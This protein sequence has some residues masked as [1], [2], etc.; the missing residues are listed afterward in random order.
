MAVPARPTISVSNIRASLV[1]LASSAYAELPDAFPLD[2]F[3]ADLGAVYSL[4]RMLTSY[5]GPLINV[6]RLSDGSA[7]DFGYDSNGDLDTAAILTFVG[8]SSAV[9]MQ[10]YD[11]GPNGLDVAPGAVANGPR[12]VLTGTLETINGRPAMG[13]FPTAGGNQ[14]WFQRATVPALTAFGA[15]EV[16][17]FAVFRQEGAQARNCLLQHVVSG[18]NLTSILATYDDV[19]YWDHADDVA[20]A[21]RINVAQPTGWDGAQH[22]MALYREPSPANSVIR[23][24]GVDRASAAQTGTRASGNATL[25]LFRD[26]SGATFHH[27]YVQ[28]LFWFTANQSSGDRDTIEAEIADYYSITLP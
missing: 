26:A 21:G 12:I 23:T 17:L 14:D 18:T 4:R 22:L 9:I 15:D 3:E 10:W 19:I 27:G 7:Q 1:D 24:D 28:E 11:Q 16:D 2:A 25:F 20:G 8:A 5:T 13:V 6:R